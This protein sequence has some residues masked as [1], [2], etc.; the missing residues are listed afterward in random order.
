MPQSWA[1]YAFHGV[2]FSMATFHSEFTNVGTLFHWG[3]NFYQ[4]GYT[5]LIILHPSGAQNSSFLRIFWS[6]KK[7]TQK[8]MPKDAGFEKLFLYTQTHILSCMLVYRSQK[9]YCLWKKLS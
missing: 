7:Y 6:F 9:V 5:F 4:I 3:D 2:N 8:V 1:F